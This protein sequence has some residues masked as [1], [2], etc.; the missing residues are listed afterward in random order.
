MSVK[1]KLRAVLLCFTLQ[2][3]VFAGIPMRPDEIEEILR[4]M[5][6]PKI[7]YTIPEEDDDG[8]PER[9]G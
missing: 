8:E 4:C 5:S 1:S 9:P 3:G 7:E 2:I 6:Q